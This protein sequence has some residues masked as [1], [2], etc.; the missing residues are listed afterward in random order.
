LGIGFS[1]QMHGLVLLDQD[2][3]LLRPAII[4]ADQRSAELL[5]EIEERVGRSLLAQQCGTPPTAGFAIAS[6]YWLQKFE[7]QTL[8]RAA[9]WMLPKDFLRL[10]LT[11]ELGTDESDAA[12]SGL[13]DVGQR[14]WADEVIG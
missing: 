11:G 13:S 5:P 12:S 8:E 7:P 4:W 10:K 3:C 9:T 6:L 14:V 1:G 2:K